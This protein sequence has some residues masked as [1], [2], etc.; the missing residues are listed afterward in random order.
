[1][2]DV[3]MMLMLIT[4]NRATNKQKAPLFAALLVFAVLRACGV[5][6]LVRSPARSCVVRS[7]KAA[8][9][10]TSTHTND[11]RLRRQEWIGK[12]DV[13]SMVQRDSGS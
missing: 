7:Q 9:R 12:D 13:E 11:V 10:L 1:M 2:V 8:S 3:V 5:I 4:T 6:D